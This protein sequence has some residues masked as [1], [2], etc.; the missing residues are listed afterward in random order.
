MWVWCSVWMNSCKKLIE[1]KNS[2]QELS[3]WNTEGERISW[4]SLLSFPLLIQNCSLMWWSCQATFCREA[5]TI[6]QWFS[7]L[8]V[9]AERLW[10]ISWYH[11]TR[12]SS[13][14]WE[15]GGRGKRSCG[16]RGHACTC[17]GFLTWSKNIFYFISY[18]VI[19]IIVVYLH[20]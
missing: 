4:K 20:N 16:S 2:P 9:L 5:N 1:R 10:C 8:I 14:G 19:I 15:A 13:T 18:T 12:I 3:W 11:T 6:S 7:N 17:K